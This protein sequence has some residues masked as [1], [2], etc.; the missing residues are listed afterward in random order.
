MSRFAAL[1]ARLTELLRRPM[2][3]AVALEVLILC[4]VLVLRLHAI[5]AAMPY[6]IHIDEP[7]L[8]E[9]AGRVLTDG[10]WN[11]HFFMYPSLPVYVTAGAF[12][13]GYL[14]AAS[15]GEVQSTRDIG[16]VGYP[17]YRQPRVVWPAKILFVLFSLTAAACA[18]WV[19]YRLTGEPALLALVPAILALSSAHHTMAWSYLNVNVMGDALVWGTLAFVLARLDDPSWYAKSIVP[20]LLLGATTATKYNF[21]SIALPALLA[22]AF[23]GGSA[24]WSKALVLVAVAAATFVAAVPYAVLDTP[25][26]L[27]DLGKIMGIYQDGFVNNEAEPGLPHLLLNL[28]KL[29][30][31]QGWLT[32][33]FAFAG[34]WSLIRRQPRRTALVTVFPLALLAHMSLQKAH[35]VRNLLSLFPLYALLV[36]T[37][38]I[39]AYRALGHWLAARPLTG[40]WLRFAPV[41][42]VTLAALVTL[43]VTRPLAAWSVTLD[44]RKVAV[45]WMLDH[46]P[47]RSTLLSAEELSIDLRPLA[48]AGH[49]IRRLKFRDETPSSLLSRLADAGEGVV[50]LYPVFGAGHWDEAV[51]AVNRPLAEELNRLRNRLRPLAEFGDG[52][53]SVVFHHVL[54]GSPQFVVGRLDLSAD[55]R[56]GIAHPR[57]VP[58][59]SF[60]ASDGGAQLA[61]GDLAVFGAEAA[62]STPIELAAGRWRLVALARGTEVRGKTARLRFTFGGRVLGT[63]QTRL[64]LREEILDFELA[65]DTEAPLEVSL[66][67]DRAE[68]RPDG[69]F[70]DRNAYLRSIQLFSLGPPGP[71]TDR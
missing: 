32:L 27:T 17:Y 54:A 44:S 5:A 29:V 9:P 13:A 60:T 63:T 71:G 15:H 11:P 20:G 46:L 1:R 34:L 50:V 30:V 28:R 2:A 18:A 35:F 55:E 67:N 45:S 40:P 26:F 36:A 23:R 6:P 65:E 64:H 48:K 10:D 56:A 57:A 43:P 14:S 33:P 12:G 4:L 8:T 3:V 59:E 16:R 58:L 49:K 69:S 39:V 42:V 7:L 19:A 51:R 31:D 37:G 21:A 70:E 41:A 53:V 68:R 25:A 47:P 66:V 62:R 22:L 52:P 61:E 24:R 38:L